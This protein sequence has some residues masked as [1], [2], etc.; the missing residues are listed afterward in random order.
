MGEEYNLKI[1]KAKLSV[2][3]CDKE[4]QAKIQVHIG[5][6]VCFGIQS[7]DCCYDATLHPI[8]S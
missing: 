6:V 1:N 4:G 5:N 2:E 8:I 7:R 3:V